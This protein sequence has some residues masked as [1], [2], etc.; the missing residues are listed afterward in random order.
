MAPQ[1]AKPEME[2]AKVLTITGLIPTIEFHMVKC[3]AEDLFKK[4][5]D[6][7][8]RPII[9]GML[10]FE[11]TEWI[12]NKK[13]H[14][15]GE[16]WAFTDPVIVY[17][18]DESLG[19]SKTFINWAIQEYNFEDFRNE[20]LYETLRKEA[21]SHYIT[22]TKND[23]VYMDYTYEDKPVGRVVLELFKNILPKTSENFRL[24]CTG[25]KGR[26]EETGTKMHY[27]N[28]IINRIVEQG[29]VQ[30]GDIISGKGNSS[31]SAYGG[32]F[33]DESFA[34]KH[35][36]RGILGM[37]NHG[38]NTNGSQFYISLQAIPFMDKKYVAFGQ[39]VEGSETL[40]KLEKINTQNQRPTKELKIVDCGQYT[41]DF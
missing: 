3:C 24:I 7:F 22:N 33:E 18:E 5:P 17:S 37:A 15:K 38:R 39:V 11:W 25:E 30:G 4:F 26:S 41:F 16:L 29:W 12:S 23:F 34:V 9:N 21:Y 32:L 36:K 13:K 19:D 6:V 1:S 28:T 40:A 8:G 10:E 35:D 2:K 31:E 20:T 27:K 14:E